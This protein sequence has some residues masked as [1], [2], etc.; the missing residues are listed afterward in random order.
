MNRVEFNIYD[1]PI[2]TNWGHNNDSRYWVTDFELAGFK[3]AINHQGQNGSMI[4]LS[5]EEFTL[6]VLRWS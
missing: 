5:A 6:F 3:T 4:S 2:F 1:F